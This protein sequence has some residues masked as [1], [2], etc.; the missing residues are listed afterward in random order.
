[1]AVPMNVPMNILHK[2]DSDPPNMSIWA[3]N[4]FKCASES[5]KRSNLRH[6][7]IGGIGLSII[8][9]VNS[10]GSKCRL[11]RRRLFSQLL[12]FVLGLL[13]LSFGF[14]VFSIKLFNGS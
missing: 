8:A 11:A 1:M 3:R 6:H 2:T 13:H 7:V 10:C 5:Q 4:T 14:S 12:T 9:F